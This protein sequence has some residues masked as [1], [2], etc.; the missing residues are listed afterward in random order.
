MRKNKL[1]VRNGTE[2]YRAELVPLTTTSLLSILGKNDER[3]TV[4]LSESDDNKLTNRQS[5]TIISIEPFRR[6]QAIANRLKHCGLSQR[7]IDVS[8]G[9]MRG[10]SN[11]NIAKQLFID[12]KTVKDH[13]QRIYAKI[14]IKT[15][16]EL[17]SKMLG[18]D[19][20]LAQHEGPTSPDPA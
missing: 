4:D 12:E 8:L 19:I 2:L 9:I 5:I 13:L 17:I 15:R 18:L 3:E 20:E 1:W 7:E 10:L 16:T 14:H 6:R 11:S